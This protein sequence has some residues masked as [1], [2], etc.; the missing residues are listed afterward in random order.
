MIATA[1]QRMRGRA[2]ERGEKMTRDLGEGIE[3][4]ERADRRELI[5]FLAE[6]KNYRIINQKL[7]YI[8]L[9]VLL[10]SNI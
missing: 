10:S 7:C 2:R 9:L 1:V 3:K 6:I 8:V 4:R 5:G